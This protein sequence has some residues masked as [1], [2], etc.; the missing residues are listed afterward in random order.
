MYEA[1]ELDVFDF[2][3]LAPP[4]R[5][6]I[7]HKHAAEHISFAGRNTFFVGFTASCP[8]FD[9]LRVRQAFAL[10]TDR[11]RLAE[12]VL[13]GY[14]AP[15]LGGFVPHG[16]PGH[17]AGI[18]L[19]YDPDRARQLL[20][21]AGYPGARDFPSV[22]AYKPWAGL[23]TLFSDFLSAQWR[24]TLGIEVTWQDRELGVT[25]ADLGI[26]GPYLS[27]QGWMV[28]Y[29]DPDNIL[30][31]GVQGTQLGWRNEA[32][33][34][35]VEK[36]QRVTHQP[37]RMRLY[38]QADRILTSEAAILPLAYERVHL[39]VKPWVTRYPVSASRWWFW[40]DVII[41]PH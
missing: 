24:E 35:L 8:P 41:E 31:L 30:R 22:S 20:A 16:L 2:A 37:E 3:W 6:R 28:D 38:R 12:V 25:P 29:P 23:F 9:D 32:Y 18:A 14:Y 27:L 7:R 26:E 5:D 10:A 4:E 1:D 33:F 11:E 39:L 40:K 13:R 34:N 17:S 21:E 36:A 15:A 19:P